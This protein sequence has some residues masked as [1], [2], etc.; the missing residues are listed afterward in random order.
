MLKLWPFEGFGEHVAQLILR[1]DFDEFDLARAMG[2]ELLTKPMIA[3]C[4]MLGAGSHATR[5]H[6]GEGESAGVVFVDTDVDVG[7]IRRK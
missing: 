4:I 7:G 1:I 6:L 5:F 2:A 3:K